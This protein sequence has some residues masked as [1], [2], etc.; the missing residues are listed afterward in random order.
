MKGYTKDRPELPETTIPGSLAHAYSSQAICGSR[1][2][3]LRVEAEVSVSD[4]AVRTLESIT[5]KSFEPSPAFGAHRA[6]EPWKK[7]WDEQAHKR[8]NRGRAS[9]EVCG[10]SARII[11]LKA[12]ESEG[13]RGESEGQP[14]D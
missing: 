11:M 7:W 5:G 8:G 2:R 14:R 1:R 3:L 6:A 9:G 12:S 4:E 13:K 10:D